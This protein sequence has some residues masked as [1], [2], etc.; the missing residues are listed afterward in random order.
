MKLEN[1]TYPEQYVCKLTFSETAEAL[2]AATQAAYERKRADLK[3]KGIERGA[4]SR[5]DA[6]AA[7]GQDF[8]WYDATNAIM[9]AEIPAIY[10]AVVAENNFF[11]VSECTYD[12]ER[13]SKDEGFVVTASFCLL[14]TFQYGDYKS[15][16]APLKAI[17]PPTDVEVDR[18]LA[19][20]KDL[21]ASRLEEYRTYV[22]QKL[23]QNKQASAVAEMQ[24]VVLLKFTALVTGEVPTPMIDEAYE[25]L[26]TQLNELLQQQQATMEQFLEQTGHTIE[27]F[28]ATTRAG[29]EARV[30]A[31]LAT[32]RLG[33][34]LGYTPTDEEVSAEIALRAEQV[35][36]KLKDFSQRANRRR[37][38]QSI[39]RQK[40]TEHIL[41]NITIT[42][43]ENA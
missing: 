10:E 20:Q 35:K 25:A 14:P 8:F 31:S 17:V 29:A 1:I 12:M 30:R 24:N 7:K 36:D 2:E 39:I 11:V 23:T 28:R 15:I 4:A 9:D 43:E 27:E 6:E 19:A 37:V 42:K 26:L 21:D 16:T 22:R 3:I 40:A 5:A 33:V 18:I 13:I 38:A 34:D 41:K 32:V